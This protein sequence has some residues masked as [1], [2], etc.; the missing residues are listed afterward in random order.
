MCEVEHV[1]FDMFF[2]WPT[3]NVT[4]FVKAIG[5]AIKAGAIITGSVIVVLVGIAD[6]SFEPDKKFMGD[7]WN[8]KCLSVQLSFIYDQQGL[9]CLCYLPIEV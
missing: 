6:M 5:K 3:A 8:K 9:Y 1:I 2:V 7:M 4:L